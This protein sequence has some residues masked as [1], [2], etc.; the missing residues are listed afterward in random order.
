MLVFSIQCKNIIQSSRKQ[1]IRN[2]NPIKIGNWFKRPI[3]IRNGINQ[4]GIET[5]KNEN[6]DTQDWSTDIFVLEYYFWFFIVLSCGENY[7]NGIES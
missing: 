1:N 3:V 2:N 6:R 7:A 4:K 5:M